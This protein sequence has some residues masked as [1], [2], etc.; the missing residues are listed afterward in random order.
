MA[1]FVISDELDQH[2]ERTFDCITD[3]TGK[4]KRKPCKFPFR[5]QNTTHHGCTTAGADD[6]VPWC[7]TLVDEEGNHVTGKAAWGNCDLNTC[8]S[9]VIT[10]GNY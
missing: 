6:D 8:K 1:A 7:S 5:F 3:D 4:Q 9:L 2:P 10:N